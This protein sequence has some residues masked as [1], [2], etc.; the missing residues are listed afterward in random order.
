[1]RVSECEEERCANSAMTDVQSMMYDKFIVARATCPFEVRSAILWALVC[2]VWARRGSRRLSR[3][4][5]ALSRRGARGLGDSSAAGARAARYP[6]RARA[7]TPRGARGR[8]DCPFSR[9]SFCQNYFVGL[10]H[11]I[12]LPAHTHHLRR[13]STTHAARL[14]REACRSRRWVTCWGSITPLLHHRRRGAEIPN[15]ARAR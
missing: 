9:L 8:G 12:R 10:Q 1:V 15:R 13:V 2:G 3:R 11:K 14:R 4:P 6:I 7:E 5:V